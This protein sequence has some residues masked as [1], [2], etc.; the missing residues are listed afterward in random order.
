MGELILAKIAYEE[1]RDRRMND[2]DTVNRLDD[3]CVAVRP[4]LE[5]LREV[6]K[7]LE[8]HAAFI[9]S[10]IIKPDGS[11]N[12]GRPDPLRAYDLGEDG[13]Y[14]VSAHLRSGKFDLLTY[15]EGRLVETHFDANT[16]HWG[17][18]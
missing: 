16:G 18:S 6:R 14:T 7:V 1:D 2:F 13:S 9:D 12:G 8:E 3:T 10:P 4:D 17:M 11:V 5:P 15:E